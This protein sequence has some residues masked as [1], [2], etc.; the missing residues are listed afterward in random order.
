L[1]KAAR[2]VAAVVGRVQVESCVYRFERRQ[3]GLT[4]AGCPA[5]SSDLHCYR[6]QD[7]I[8]MLRLRR[9]FARFWL[10]CAESFHQP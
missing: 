2:L 8:R 9:R 5:V 7:R 3:P 6:L 4:L 10:V 1:D